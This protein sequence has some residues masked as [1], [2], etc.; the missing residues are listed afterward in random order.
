M[1]VLVADD[2]PSFRS[3]LADIFTELGVGFDAVASGQDCFE[4]IYHNS[5]AYSLVL[6]DIHMPYKSGPATLKQIRHDV[7]KLSKH[8]PIIAMTGDQRW[9]DRRLA[10]EAGFCGVLMKP[11]RLQK[12]TAVLQALA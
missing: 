10:V 2:D 1:K 5:R 6:M 12:L 3:L 4:L 9:K 8:L 11:I 7:H